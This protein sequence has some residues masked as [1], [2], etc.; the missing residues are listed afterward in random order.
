MKQNIY[1]YNNLKE[2][3][4]NKH[5]DR[6]KMIVENDKGELLFASSNNN[7]YL[8]G[9]HVDEG[10]TFDECVVREIKEESGVDIPY[11]KREPYFATIYYCKDY[12]EKG[13][14]TKYTTYFYSIKY[15]LIP[16]TDNINLTKDE[17]DGGFK[18]EYID[19]NKAVDVLTKA[20]DTCS[21]KVVVQDTLDAVINYLKK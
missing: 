3:D 7:Y 6:A 14:N 20:L 17:I 13:V 2:E 8:I 16:K 18:L 10:E 19:K 11:E 12:P 9:G 5:V 1:K 15:N 21:I 4:I